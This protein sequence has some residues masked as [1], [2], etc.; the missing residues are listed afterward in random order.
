MQFIAKDYEDMRK[1]L[2]AKGY[3]HNQAEEIVKYFSEI[4]G[5]KNNEKNIIYS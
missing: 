3:L 4:I 1:D 5:K 2:L